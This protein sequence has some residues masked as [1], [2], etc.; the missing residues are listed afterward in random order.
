MPL[1]E[2]DFRAVLQG[3]V[4]N[5]LEICLESGKFS[6][7]LHEIF[8]LIHSDLDLS[9]KF[10][11][12]NMGCMVSLLYLIWVVWLGDPTVDQFEGNHLVFVAAGSDPFD[13]ITKAVKYVTFLNTI[14]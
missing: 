6:I 2:G 5:E 10:V 12:S 13:V 14:S 4:A 9:C 3:N 7:Y 8:I 11:R 1:L